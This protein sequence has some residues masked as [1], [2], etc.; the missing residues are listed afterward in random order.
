MNFLRNGFPPT[1]KSLL[2]Q[3]K[4]D[5]IL[6]VVTDVASA[7]FHTFGRLARAAGPDPEM[8]Q[9]VFSGKQTTKQAIDEYEA[10]GNKK[11][12]ENLR[13]VEEAKKRGSY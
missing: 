13:L 6:T 5:P 3:T 9:Q 8:Y 7:N 1:R 12:E 11:L 4:E 10:R 2:E